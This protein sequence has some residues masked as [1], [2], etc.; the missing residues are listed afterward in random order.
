MTGCFGSHCE[1]R[2]HENELNDYLRSQE[3]MSDSCTHCGELL[4]VSDCCPDCDYEQD[5][6]EI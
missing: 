4:D 1:D 5:S 6:K 3:F 2:H